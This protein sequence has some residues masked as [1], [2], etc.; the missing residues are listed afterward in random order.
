MKYLHQFGLMLL[1]L[2]VIAC[3]ESE[4][5]PVPDTNDD[6]KEDPVPSKFDL[7]THMWDI[8][9][10]THAGV[11]DASSTGKEIQFF[12][13]GRYD[14]NGSLQGNWHF[15]AD[16]SMVIIDEGLSYQQDWTIKDLTDERFEV[17][18]RSPFTGKKSKWIMYKRF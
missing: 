15:N 11:Y 13:T 4:P 5:K 9:T 3:S 1:L 2:L 12:K 7:I 14:F 18:F 16:S 17:D 8:D 10:A 6:P